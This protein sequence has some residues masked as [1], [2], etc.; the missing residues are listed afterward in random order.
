MYAGQQAILME[1]ARDAVDRLDR[2]TRQYALGERTSYRVVAVQL[3][4]LLCDTTR[5]HGQIVDISL[6]ERLWPDL[7]LHPLAATQ[8]K[9]CFDRHAA[10]LARLAW[11]EQNFMPPGGQAMTLRDAIRLVC[12]RDGGAHVDP[13]ARQRLPDLSDTISAIGAYIAAELRPLTQ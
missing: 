4:M 7:A 6:A 5:R 3:R 1:Y 8:A 12:D 11:L 13:P 9:L 2:S 10:R